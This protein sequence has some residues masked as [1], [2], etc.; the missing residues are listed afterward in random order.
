MAKNTRGWYI[1]EDGAEIW[2]YGLSA[3]E[4]ANEIREHGKIIKFIPTN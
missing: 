2:F 4:K 1:F 3:Q